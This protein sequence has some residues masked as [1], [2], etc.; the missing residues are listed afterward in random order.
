MNN[1]IYELMKFH[2]IVQK[3]RLRAIDD[4]NPEFLQQITNYIQTVNQTS[5][6]FIK[7]TY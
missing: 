1:N 3:L 4:E 5:D 6:N 2:Q 7:H